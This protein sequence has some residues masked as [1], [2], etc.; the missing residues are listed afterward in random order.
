MGD[1]EPR[2]GKPNELAQLRDELRSAEQAVRHWE[3]ELAVAVRDAQTL[4]SAWYVAWTTLTGT[5]DRRLDDAVQRVEA[6]QARLAKARLAVDEAAAALAWAEQQAAGAAEV[7]RERDLARE[8][9][10][11]R[12]R[13]ASGPEAEALATLERD[14]AELGG[15][16]D[17]LTRALSSVGGA[18]AAA[19][20]VARACEAAVHSKRRDL[21][22]V[23][24]AGLLSIGDVAQVRSAVQAWRERAPAVRGALAA[25]G[26]DWAPGG[27]QGD[28]PSLWDEV[29]NDSY[30]AEL[31]QLDRLVELQ[32]DFGGLRDELEQIL[33]PIERERRDLLARQEELQAR[34]RELLD[35][36]S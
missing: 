36:I 12:L 30:W 32:T 31:R 1:L 18:R 35:R 21:W 6:L 27:L 3:A 25:I 10:A 23:P 11:G 15:R 20:Q 33:I 4:D 9:A 28:A 8:A 22:N 16:I 17:G 19:G 2:P 13:S 24:L 29:S 5:R 26:L 34:R 7:A 14:L